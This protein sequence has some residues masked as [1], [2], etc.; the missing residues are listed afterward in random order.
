[1]CYVLLKPCILILKHKIF[2]CIILIYPSVVH[3]GFAMDKVI[4]GHVLLTTLLF[5]CKLVFT[6]V[7]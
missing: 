7:P 4:L 6:N 2:T 3:M 5:P 1:M